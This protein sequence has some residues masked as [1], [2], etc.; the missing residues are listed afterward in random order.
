MLELVASP[1]QRKFGLDK[2]DSLTSQCRSCEV[3]PLCNGGCPKDR[4]VASRD[5]EPGHNYLCQGLELFYKH[6][7]PAMERMA[8]LLRE[9]LPA[10]NI[11]QWVAAQ[12]SKRGGND[13]CPCKGGRKFKRCHGNTQLVRRSEARS[14]AVTV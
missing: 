4:F 7:R 14:S 6:T 11:M 2:R 8:G 9:G 10:A 1:Q 5:G 3:R 12:D 13:P